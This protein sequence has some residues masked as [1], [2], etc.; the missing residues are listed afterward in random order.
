MESDRV[1]RWLMFASNVGVL[2]GLVF[3]G[4]EVRNSGNAVTAQVATA[5]SEGYN[6][7]NYLVATDPDVARLLYLGVGAPD[8]LTDSESFRASFLIRGIFNHYF[9]VHKLYRAGILTESE[10]AMFAPEIN[11]AMRQPGIKIYFDGI[12]AIKSEIIDEFVKDVMRYE[13]E[14]YESD[15]TQGRGEI[16]IE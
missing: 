8:K 5:I 2:I 11:M 12:K 3:V 13:S 10:W 7:F 1:N 15:Y 16:D 14:S 6:D 4:V 9:Q